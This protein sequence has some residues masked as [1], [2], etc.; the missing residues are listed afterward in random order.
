VDGLINPL[1]LLLIVIVMPVVCVLSDPARAVELGQTQAQSVAIGATTAKNAA[2]S[3][4]LWDSSDEVMA[5]LWGLTVPEVQRARM[6]MHGPRGAFSSPQLSPIEAL[7]IHARSA[8]ERDRYARLLAKIIYDDVER[9]RA[10]SIQAEAELQRLTAGQPVIDFEHA[11]K[12]AVS[13]EAA[14]V[15]GVPRSAVVPPPKPAAQIKA[16]PPINKAISRA[17]DNRGRAASAARP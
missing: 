7:G 1:R 17:V 11:P 15:L 16:K 3:S 10:F 5:Q 4:P 6:L 12:A 8:A 13:Y 9:S 2:R 14:E